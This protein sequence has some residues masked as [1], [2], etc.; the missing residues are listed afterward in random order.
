MRMQ[1]SLPSGII[2][3]EASPATSSSEK[4]ENPAIRSCRRRPC[5]RVARKSFNG[6]R[7]EE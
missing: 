3:S 2:R 5:N 7:R 6:L 1:F 4:L